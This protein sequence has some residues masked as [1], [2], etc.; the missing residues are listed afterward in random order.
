MIG[1][2]VHW[3]CLS[4]SLL[5]DRLAAG[6]RIILWI[7]FVL[8][9]MAE[10]ADAAQPAASIDAPQW[11]GSPRRNNVAVGKNLPIEWEVGEIDRRSGQWDRDSAQNIRWV[12]RLGSQSYGTPI[13]AGDRVFCA[14]NN[15]AGWLARY[16]SEVDLGCL[17]AFTR[18]AGEFLWQ[19]SAEKLKAGRTLDWPQQGICS[20]PLV[21]GDR[22]WVVTNRGEVVC[23][24]TEGFRDGQNDAPYDQEPVVAEN[25]S[26]VVWLFNMMKELGI[27]QHNMCSCSVTAA[28]D[29]LLVNTSNGVDETHENIPAPEA[30]SFIALDKHTGELVWAD[31]SPGHNILH[32]QWS[33]PAFAVLG[34]TPQAIFAGG[35][36]WLYSFLAEPTDD[37]KPKLLWRFDCNPKTA[38]WEG[39]GRGDRGN[40]IAAPV[41]SAGYVY[42]VTGQDPEYGEGQGYLWCID[43]TRRGDVS[44][45][46]VFDQDGNPVPPRRVQN[47]DPEAGEVTRPNPNSAAVWMYAGENVEADEQ[48]GFMETLHRSLATPAIADGLLVLPDYS[49]LIHCLDAKT[50]KRCWA[51]DALSTIWGSPLIV[52]GKVYVADEDGDVA[53]L[54]LGREENLLAEPNMGSSVYSSPVVHDNVLY[55]ATRSHLIA[56]A[57]ADE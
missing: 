17:L 10:I 35:D 38:R 51:Y 45:E 49:G 40:I 12:A 18:D 48:R 53:V 31:N 14:T 5:R 56:I 33:S 50:G 3:Y 34:G 26:D 19:H 37:R 32:G 7:G 43:P 46:L 4:S 20:S 13:I 2:S 27:V 30:P 11:G 21:E 8:A 29:L 54:E 47:C 39:D 15:G 55:I 1:P 25:E 22:L 42:A 52:E 44:A 24:D 57:S 23:L 28:G 16:P 36:G 41:I 9:A 6:G